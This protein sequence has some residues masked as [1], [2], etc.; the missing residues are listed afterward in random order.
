MVSIDSSFS[1][2]WAVL[3]HTVLL[4]CMYCN[5]LV[6]TGNFNDAMC[7]LWNSEFLISPGRH[8]LVLLL[9]VCIV[10][11]LDE[12]SKISFLSCLFLH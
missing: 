9:F 4:H 10:T 6:T 12:S 1:H 7:K 2:V 8:L 11:F 5:F 3:G